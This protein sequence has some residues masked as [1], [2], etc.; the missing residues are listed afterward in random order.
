MSVNWISH[1]Q[2]AHKNACVITH[3]EPW[4]PCLSPAHPTT[5]LLRNKTSVWSSGTL[6]PLIVPLVKN[7]K[8]QQETQDA[9]IQSPTQFPGNSRKA[10]SLSKGKTH[11]RV[12]QSQH[13]ELKAPQCWYMTDSPTKLSCFVYIWTFSLSM[14]VPSWNF[15]LHCFQKQTGS[16]FFEKWPLR[17]LF[18]KFSRSNFTK[19]MSSDHIYK[20][21]LNTTA[22]LTHFIIQ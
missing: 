3:N 11:F 5:V 14:T 17:L 12:I 4:I 21:F 18:S 16:A 20:Y 1:R 15:H 9:R 6:Q 10:V 8:S 7:W 13:V 22:L 19:L 2:S